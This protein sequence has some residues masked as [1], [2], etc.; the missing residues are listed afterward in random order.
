MTIVLIFYLG[1]GALSKLMPQVQIFFV[2]ISANIMLGF[3]IMVLLV[4]VMMIWFVEYFKA[5][6]LS[7]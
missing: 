2:A 7:F 6:Y 5:P 4:S 3:L 1:I